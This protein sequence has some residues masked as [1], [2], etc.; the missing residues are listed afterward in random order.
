MNKSNQFDKLENTPNRLLTGKENKNPSN[1]SNSC[2]FIRFTDF[3]INKIS[4]KFLLK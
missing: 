4:I 2:I 3:V 1:S